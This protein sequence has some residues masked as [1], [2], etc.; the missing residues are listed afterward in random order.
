MPHAFVITPDLFTQGLQM[1]VPV[2]QDSDFTAFDSL[3]IPADRLSPSQARRSFSGQSP[4][5]ILALLRSWLVQ[6]L[7][8]LLR[9]KYYSRS[10]AL[11]AYFGMLGFAPCSD[12]F[13]APPIGLYI[14]SPIRWCIAIIIIAP[15]HRPP[16]QR[17]NLQ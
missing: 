9:F 16:P 1:S 12:C 5:L 15:T 3:M 7:G 8:F 6:Y 17:A 13:L 14:I 2:Q 10:S 11:S 4:K